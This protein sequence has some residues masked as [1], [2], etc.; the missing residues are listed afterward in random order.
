[1]AYDRAAIYNALLARLQ[2]KMNATSTPPLPQPVSRRAKDLTQLGPD[3]QPAVFLVADDE[4]IQQEKGQSPKRSFHAQILIY[5]R[6]EDPAQ[7]PTDILFPLIQLA[8]QAIAW[9]PGDTP[10]LYGSSTTLGGLVSHCRLIKLEMNDGLPSG[11]GTA[12]L[13]LDLLAFGG[14]AGTGV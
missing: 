13:T 4:Q 2:A 7:A 10:V 14:V 6:T 1:V 11:E 9:V 5:V 12:L 8:E 3:E